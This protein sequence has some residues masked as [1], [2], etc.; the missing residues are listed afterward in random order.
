[1]KHRNDRLV[2]VHFFQNY[3]GS[4]NF[5][6]TDYRDGFIH[7]LSGTCLFSS[8]KKIIRVVDLNVADE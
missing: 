6:P 4:A 7:A 8:G 3:N 2:T 5:H 1:M